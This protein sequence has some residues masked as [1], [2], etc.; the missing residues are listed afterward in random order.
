LALPK[1]IKQKVSKKVSTLRKELGET[2]LVFAQ[3]F[4]VTQMTVYR[5]E[6]EVDLPSANKL[7]EMGKI[8]PEP[9]KWFFFEQAGLSREEVVEHA[10]DSAQEAAKPVAGA[11]NVCLLK[12]ISLLKSTS[13]LR[14]Q[15]IESTICLPAP[16][17]FTG[18]VDK[19]FAIRV[20]GDSMSPTLEE[21]YLA[22]IEITSVGRR[23]L[24]GDI[25]AALNPAND[26]VIGRLVH[27]DGQELLEPENK[28]FHAHVIT[29]RLDWKILGRIILWI[30]S[31]KKKNL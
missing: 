31:P 13:S 21:G 10:Q 18:Q 3:R 19:V 27:N 16:K 6:T 1:D 11:M 25:V 17:D 2:R 24:Y 7:L 12:R 15:D 20:H 22:V 5:W 29:G 8:A 23:A 30:G 9:L 28:R 4:G 26:I 14:E